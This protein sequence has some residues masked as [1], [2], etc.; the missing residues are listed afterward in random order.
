MKKWGIIGRVPLR[1]KQRIVILFV[2]ALLAVSWPVGSF[3]AQPV[4]V[5]V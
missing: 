1:K 5:I 3:A 4:T 2:A